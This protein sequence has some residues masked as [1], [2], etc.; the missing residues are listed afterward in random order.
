MSV[1]LMTPERL[2]V[3]VGSLTIEATDHSHAIVKINGQDVAC[4]GLT[5]KLRL[6]AVHRVHLHLLPTVKTAQPPAAPTDSLLPSAD[7]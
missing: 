4:T 6:D 2:S 1:E 3:R 5:L 7:P